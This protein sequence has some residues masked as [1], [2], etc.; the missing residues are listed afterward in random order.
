MTVKHV[1]VFTAN[2]AEYGLLAPLLQAIDHAEDL[3][4]N[5]M[6]AQ[7]HWLT[8][9]VD[10]ITADGFAI[11]I[12]LKPNADAACLEQ[13]GQRMVALCADLMTQ[14]ANQ[15]RHLDAL[16]ILGDRFEA[17]ACA[18]AARLLNIPIIH[19]GGGDMTQGGC[20]D[21]DLRYMISCLASWHCPTTHTSQ[22]RL[23]HMGISPDRT[24]VTG[25]LVYD[26][27]HQ[28]PLLH[29]TALFSQLGLHCHQPVALF[30]QHP[31]PAEGLTTVTHFD[32]SLV[33]LHTLHTTLGLQTVATYPNRDGYADALQ[34]VINRH[35]WAVWVP[36]LGRLRY[37]S[38]MAVCNVVVGNTS[39]GLIETPF[40]NVPSVT[41]GPRQAGRE[42]GNNVLVS[43][44]GVAPVKHAIEHALFMQPVT[45]NPFGQE[46]AVP[47]IMQIIRQAVIER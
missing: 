45:H 22:N 37:L 11:A 25:S 4:L 43:D 12:P 32:H 30:T 40:F 5:L 28:Q 17:A 2:R 31:I 44:Y 29:K 9:S 14:L 23:L 20:V 42:K 34:T 1:G 26:N 47:K 3:A 8:G 27:I 10:E 46:P 7:D 16:V 35:N 38:M 41:I 39:S 21:D 33:A 19:I 24:F 18:M 36:S 13:P 15:T 6:V